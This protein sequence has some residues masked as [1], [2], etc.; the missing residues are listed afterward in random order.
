MQAVI[1]AIGDGRLDFEVAVVI[2]NNADAVALERAASNDIPAVHL[3]SRTHPDPP[4]LDREM[5]DTLSGHGCDWILL[6]G[7]MKLVGPVTLQRF[8]GRILNIHPAL[9]PEF[10]GPGMYGA[11]VHEAVIAAGRKVTGVTIH[12]V[13][14]EYDR[15]P[16]IARREVPVLE[17]DTPGTLAQRVLEQEHEFLVTTLR[18][19]AEGQYPLKSPRHRDRRYDRPS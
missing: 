16:I 6:A 19:I 15:G 7:Y 10:G 12:L 11:K 5:A 18:E 8:E 17:S 14:E 3:S 1:D 13:D 4:A 2:S 9:L